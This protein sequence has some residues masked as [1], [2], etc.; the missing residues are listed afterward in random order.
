MSRELVEYHQK[1][2]ENTREEREKKDKIEELRVKLDNILKQGSVEKPLYHFSYEIVKLRELGDNFGD[3]EEDIQRIALFLE[4]IFNQ[5]PTEGLKN[6]SALWSNGG[7]QHAALLE[8]AEKGAADLGQE[9][10]DKLKNNSG[11]ND[12]SVYRSQLERKLQG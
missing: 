11:I 2:M 8:V 1:V 5:D 10:L 12:L 4:R 9:E 7:L 6:F 3:S